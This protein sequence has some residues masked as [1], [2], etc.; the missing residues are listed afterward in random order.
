MLL[1]GQDLSRTMADAP[2]PPLQ[3]AATPKRAHFAFSTD[4][5][6][7]MRAAPE[8]PIGCP[9]ATA[10]PCTFTLQI[11]MPVRLILSRTCKNLHLSMQQALHNVHEM[12]LCVH[13]AACK[14]TPIWIQAEQ[15]AVDQVHHAEGLINL[16]VVYVVQCE[17]CGLQRPRDG[18]SWSCRELVWLALC[19]PIPPYPCQYLQLMGCQWMVRLQGTPLVFCSDATTT[20]PMRSTQIH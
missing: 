11:S 6:R 19:I 13:A 10:P 18:Q 2:P 12:S 3:M 17:P 14:H 20:P 7:M 15:L 1:N 16:K 8:A 5:S 9:I 4:S